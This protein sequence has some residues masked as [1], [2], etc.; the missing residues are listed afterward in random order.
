MSILYPFCWWNLVSGLAGGA[1]MEVVK[2]CELLSCHPS[3]CHPGGAPS[4]V[5]GED[6]SPVSG[7]VQCSCVGL[8]VEKDKSHLLLPIKALAFSPLC[9][10]FI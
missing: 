10:L 7:K 8:G 6:Y 9:H 1:G 3:S 4:R 2:C 5:G